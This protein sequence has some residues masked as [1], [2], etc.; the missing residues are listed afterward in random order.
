MFTPPNQLEK[1]RFE[2]ILS[3]T[4]LKKSTMTYQKRTSLLIIIFSK[5]LV[6]RPGRNPS[7]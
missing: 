7:T 1:G 4:M 2:K 5:L 6:V 3:K